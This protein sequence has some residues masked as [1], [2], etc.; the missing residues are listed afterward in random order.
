MGENLTLVHSQIF[1]EAQ[2]L[3]SLY[4]MALNAEQRHYNL[5]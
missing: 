5:V 3:Q 2:V 4:W 1:L